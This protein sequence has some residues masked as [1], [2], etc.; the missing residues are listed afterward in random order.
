MDF[1]KTWEKMFEFA[2]N[3]P[4]ILYKPVIERDFGQ[5]RFLTE[6]PTCLIKEGKFQQVDILT[7]LTQYEFVNPAISEFENNKIEVTNLEVL[8]SLRYFQ[9]C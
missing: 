8:F 4:I 7:G 1:A 6:H 3:Q 2:K 5:E 9:K